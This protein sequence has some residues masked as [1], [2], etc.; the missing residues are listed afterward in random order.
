MSSSAG[1]SLEHSQNTILEQNQSSHKMREMNGHT[2][3]HGNSF[4][5]SASLSRRES[6][7]LLVEN[8]GS[9]LRFVG[10]NSEHIFYKSTDGGEY[11][12]LVGGGSG[13]INT[14]IRFQVVF[15]YIGALDVIQGQVPVTFRITLFWNED[16]GV[17]SSRSVG[18]NNDDAES[19]SSSG[20]RKVSWTMRGR[21]IAVQLEEKNES[22][23]QTV[24]IPPISILN[25]VTFDTIGEPEVALLRE[26]TGLW[27]WSCM[28]RASLIQVSPSLQPYRE[29]LL[30]SSFSL[31]LMGHCFSCQIR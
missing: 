27:R 19:A 30:L 5:S 4:G 12:S 20:T 11:D 13:P 23:E 29:H 14:A 31:L 10:G 21:Q 28:Y 2:R 17:T 9:K 8:N 26:D 18:A 15:W 7:S 6:D 24:D 22:E 1:G 25:V 3:R 16:V